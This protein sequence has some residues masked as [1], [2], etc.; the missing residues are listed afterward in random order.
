MAVKNFV[1]AVFHKCIK[2]E[3]ELHKALTRPKA[4][5]TFQ[6][7]IPQ[8]I[9]LYRDFY[10]CHHFIFLLSEDMPGEKLTDFWVEKMKFCK[11]KAGQGLQA[12][13]RGLLLPRGN[14]FEN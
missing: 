13:Q 14:P 8:F 11:Y 9:D 6:Q 4:P 7:M 2:V 5:A 1:I 12:L 3:N 10:R